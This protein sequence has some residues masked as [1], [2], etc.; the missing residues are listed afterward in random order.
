MAAPPPWRRR[1]SRCCLSILRAVRRGPGRRWPSAC[2]RVRQE[3][4]AAYSRPSIGPA[5]RLIASSTCCQRGAGVSSR[6]TLPRK[7]N[8]HRATAW[9]GKAPSRRRCASAGSSSTVAAS[10]PRP[11]CRVARTASVGDDT[12]SSLTPWA[13]RN[14]SSCRLRYLFAEAGSGDWRE[15]RAWIA[16]VD[17]RREAL[18]I[19]VSSSTTERIGGGGIPRARLSGPGSSGRTRRTAQQGAGVGV[20][21]GVVGGS[22]RPRPPGRNRPV[23][24]VPPRSIQRWLKA[25]DADLV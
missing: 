7:S 18:A 19:R 15:V 13:L 5:A 6:S 12:V 8:E 16:Q 10:A 24:Q 3:V 21:A 2:C 22:G 4:R 11:A 14:A 1:P 25:G 17:Q 9:P 23:A 20:A